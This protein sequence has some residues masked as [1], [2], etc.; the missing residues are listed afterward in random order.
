MFKL[1]F[2]T[3]PPKPPVFGEKEE[4]EVCRRSVSRVSSGSILIQ[5]GQYL[6]KQDVEAKK[7]ELLKRRT[8]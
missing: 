8:K 6:T 5:R 4:R 1:F 2:P 3:L 7:K